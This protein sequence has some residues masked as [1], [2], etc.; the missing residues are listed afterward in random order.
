MVPDSADIDALGAQ[1]ADDGVAYSNPEL[2]N[3]QDVQQPV[4]DALQPGHGVAVVDVQLDSLADAR[5]IA[6]DLQN[7]SGLDTVIV[8]VPGRVSAVSDS[9][10]RAEIETAQQAVPPGADQVTLLETFYGE[11]DSFSIPWIWV[12]LAVLILIAAVS[13]SAWRSSQRGVQ[14]TTLADTQ[15]VSKQAPRDSRRG[16]EVTKNRA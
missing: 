2:A 6:T 9:L 12:S 7:A 4:I 11:L 15:R 1:L 8:Q 5:D 14:S 13:V 3:N 16:S 10:S